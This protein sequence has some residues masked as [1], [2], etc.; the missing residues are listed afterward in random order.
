MTSSAEPGNSLGMT[1]RLIP[2][3]ARGLIRSVTWTVRIRCE[4]VQILDELEST[5]RTAILPFFHGRQFLLTGFLAGRKLG[6]MSSFS[7][8][9]ELQTHVMTG[10]GFEV[11]R[12]SASRGGARGLIG[13]KRLMEKGYHATVA[14]DGPLGSIHC[15]GGVVTFLH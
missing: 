14:V 7:R 6:V 10:L 9:G 1:G 5:G 15:D 12:G 3:L 13:L 2:L 8:D 11:V 4:G